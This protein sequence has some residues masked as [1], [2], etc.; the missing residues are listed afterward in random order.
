MLFM[1]TP[2]KIHQRGKER[3]T[4]HRAMQAQPRQMYPLQNEGDDL[5]LELLL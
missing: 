3:E 5:L 1:Q 2:Q 4:L